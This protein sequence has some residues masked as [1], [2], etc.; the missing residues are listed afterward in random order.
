MA[1]QQ[2]SLRDFTLEEVPTWGGRSGRTGPRLGLSLQ[3]AQ[4]G[5][6]GRFFCRGWGA[7]DQI[8]IAR[9]EGAAPPTH[10]PP[11]PLGAVAA[12]RGGGSRLTAHG[13]PP[14]ESGVQ[15]L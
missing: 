5:V 4:E 3:Q 1:D 15:K 13:S 6:D 12:R 8:W 7:L 11:R 10:C 9:L 2:Q 14:G